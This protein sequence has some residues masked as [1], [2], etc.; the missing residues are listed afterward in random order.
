MASYSPPNPFCSAT[1]AALRAA[2]AMARAR[3]PGFEER[4]AF[5]AALSTPAPPVHPA[6]EQPLLVSLL[7]N[8]PMDALPTAPLSD[9]LRQ[10][11]FGDT[12]E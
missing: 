4:V 8:V 1:F 10:A 3:D 5:A 11:L 9:E 7:G 12:S 2:S 6:F